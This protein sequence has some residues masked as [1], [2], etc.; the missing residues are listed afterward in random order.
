LEICKLQVFYFEQTKIFRK[1]AIPKLAIIP[2]FIEFMVESFDFYKEDID[3]Y[4][5][6]GYTD[7]KKRWKITSEDIQNLPPFKRKEYN[8]TKILQKNTDF[9]TVINHKTPYV[10]NIKFLECEELPHS[11]QPFVIEKMGEIELDY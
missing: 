3:D 5:I 6:W 8:L 4:F 1:I 7:N 10:F 2:K 11:T 9:I